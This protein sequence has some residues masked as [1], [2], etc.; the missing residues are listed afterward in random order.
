VI[1]RA[2]IAGW[3]LLELLELAY[4]GAEVPF[5][6][7]AASGALLQLVESTL[8]VCKLHQPSRQKSTSE[9]A[10]CCR[11]SSCSVVP[12]TSR[13]SLGCS[14]PSQSSSPASSTWAW[15]MIHRPQRPPLCHSS[16]PIV[17]TF[18]PSCE[19]PACDEQRSYVES[20][21]AEHGSLAQH[22]IALTGHLSPSRI[23]F[24]P[25]CMALSM[26]GLC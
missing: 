15:P 1:V 19:G 11:T 10:V 17:A 9:N 5:L 18:P 22:S 16:R 20:K 23:E 2:C 3:E 26:L 21:C 6:E 7:N 13:Q 14:V 12:C 4:Q 8:D 24:E 25:L